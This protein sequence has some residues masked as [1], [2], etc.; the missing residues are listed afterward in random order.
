MDLSCLVHGR[1]LVL[2]LDE[3]GRPVSSGSTLEERE[4]YALQYLGRR[5]C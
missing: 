5:H 1:S 4:G 3:Q 2:A